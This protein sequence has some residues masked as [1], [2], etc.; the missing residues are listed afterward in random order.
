MLEKRKPS[1]PLTKDISSE[2]AGSNPVLLIF[3]HFSQKRGNP[4]KEENSHL[5]IVQEVT[6]IVSFCE[7]GGKLGG[8]YTTKKLQY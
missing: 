4:V 2:H 1:L 8:V 3:V 6:K 5:C 7:N